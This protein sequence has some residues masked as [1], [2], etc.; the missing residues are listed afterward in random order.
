MPNRPTRA[1]LRTRPRTLIVAAAVAATVAWAVPGGPPPSAAQAPQAPQSAGR[2]SADPA[3]AAPPTH[4]VEVD[5]RTVRPGT[6]TTLTY[7]VA[8]DSDEGDGSARLGLIG[9]EATGTEL[10]TTDPRCVNPLTGRYPST[11]RNAHALDCALTDLQPGRPAT[12]VVHAA[13]KDTCG[14]IVS[15]LSYWM[16]RGQELHTDRALA[17]PTVGCE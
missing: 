1:S 17:G 4:R 2:A 6:V 12:V 11:T 7:T 14:T 8:R 9:E 16:P 15:K 13:V 5:R 10:T 3:G